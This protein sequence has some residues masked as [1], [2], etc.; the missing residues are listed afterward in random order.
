MLL[1]VTDRS[2][3]ILSPLAKLRALDQSPEWPVFPSVCRTYTIGGRLGASHDEKFIARSLANFNRNLH[4]Q[5]LV[6]VQV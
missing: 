1:P 4:F 6:K 3:G 2:F 5:R